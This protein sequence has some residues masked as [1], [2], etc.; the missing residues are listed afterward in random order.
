MT[1]CRERGRDGV[2]PRKA[3][4]VALGKHSIGKAG[5]ET[6]SKRLTQRERLTRVICWSQEG[7]SVALG[8]TFRWSCSRRH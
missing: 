8:Q 7:N 3:K 4:V 6:D 2:G 5:E 1:V